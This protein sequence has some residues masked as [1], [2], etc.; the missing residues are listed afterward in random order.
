MSVAS[1]A[2]TVDFTGS[3]YRV[4]MQGKQFH[5]VVFAFLLSVEP[6]L[7]HL[8]VS[9]SNITIALGSVEASPEISSSISYAGQL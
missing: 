3:R 4:L 6:V 7:N 8:Y 5:L 1:Y 2:T 9:V